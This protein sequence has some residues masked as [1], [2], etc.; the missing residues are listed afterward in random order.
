MHAA[1]FDA[2]RGWILTMRHEPV[3]WGNAPVL[4]MRL[5]MDPNALDLDMAD[6]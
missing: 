1:I 6:R 4:V 2:Q 5:G 3:F